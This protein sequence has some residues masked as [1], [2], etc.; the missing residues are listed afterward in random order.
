MPGTES[1]KVLVRVRPLSSDEKARG[2]LQVLQIDPSTAQVTALNPKTQTRTGFSFNAV[3]GPDTC[4]QEIYDQAVFGLVESVLEGYNGTIFAY[5][6]TGCG[7]TFTMAGETGSPGVIPNSFKHL[8][9]AMSDTDK[10]KCFL[11]RCS[12]M[13][14]YN[15]EIR[16]LLHYDPTSRLELKEGKDQ[17]IF[18]KGLTMATVA[19]LTDMT[20]IMDAGSRHRTTK[21]TMMNERSSRSHAIFTVYL[22]M[23]EEL[24]GR[25]VIKAGKLNLVDLAGSERQNKTQAAGDRLREAI[26][27]NLSLSALGNVIT[28]LVDGK[29]AHIPYRDS[30][31]TRLLQ[32]SLGGNTKTTVNVPAVN[33]ASPMA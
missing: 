29:S 6:Q 13:E 27:I 16:D 28:A 26:E 2:C 14:I 1:V 9:G 11:V 19:S 31:L 22:E 30:K 18:I 25:T 33:G 4:Q 15:E 3:F 12:Y 24:E 32:D 17:G 23:S 21:E 20:H 5:G 8:F 7:K 10:S